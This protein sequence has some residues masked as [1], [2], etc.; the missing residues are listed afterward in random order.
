MSMPVQAVGGG[1][2]KLPQDNLQAHSRGGIEQV[3]EPEQERRHHRCQ[4]DTPW[5][6]HAQHQPAIERLFRE[7]AEEGRQQGQAEEHWYQRSEL[8]RPV[9]DDVDNDSHQEDPYQPQVP[10][11]SAM[12]CP[13]LT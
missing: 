10:G 1:I 4:P 9:V 5:Q 13:L 12:T 7:A 8:A 11:P 6:K 3:G 2:E